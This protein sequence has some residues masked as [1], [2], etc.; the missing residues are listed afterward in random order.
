[1]SS[2]MI[3]PLSSPEAPTSSNLSVPELERNNEDVLVL[4]NRF[5][6]WFAK[7]AGTSFLFE[8]GGKVYKT[9]LP[10]STLYLKF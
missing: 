5:A 4:S 2:P 8:Q 1:M 7:L 6:K 9:T 3:S 10:Q